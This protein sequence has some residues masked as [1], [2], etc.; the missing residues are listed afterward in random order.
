[1]ALSELQTELQEAYTVEVSV[2]TIARTLQ[3]EGYT[4]KS[5]HRF[6]FSFRLD[7]HLQHHLVGHTLCSR[8][9]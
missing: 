8:A 2:T 7:Q 6:S 5:V 1:M 3:R 9:K 4:M